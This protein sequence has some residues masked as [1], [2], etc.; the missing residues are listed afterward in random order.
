MTGRGEFHPLAGRVVG[1]LL[2]LLAPRVQREGASEEDSRLV[3]RADLTITDWRPRVGIACALRIENRG[4][5][6]VRLCWT[7]PQPPVASAHAVG[8]RVGA[9]TANGAVCRVNT[10]ERGVQ[11]AWR[12]G[13]PAVVLRQTGPVAA[14]IAAGWLPPSAAMAVTSDHVCAFEAGAGDWAGV[15]HVRLDAALPLRDRSTLPTVARARR[16]GARPASCVLPAAA[17]CLLTGVLDRLRRHAGGGVAFCDA[18]RDRAVF[19]G[20]LA[21]C[22]TRVL[23][24]QAAAPAVRREAPPAYQRVERLLRA[25]R[26]PFRDAAERARLARGLTALGLRHGLV[27]P[28]TALLA[29]D[30]AGPCG[31]LLPAHAAEG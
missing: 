5:A 12:A 11:R 18:A 26:E 8:V 22:P 31:E 30:A 10:A 23:L 7:V 13:R 14:S 28:W 20:Q 17:P 4:G 9:S 6:A 2:A 21:G 3:L 19:R 27:T 15:L 29:V 16:S 1:W 25:Y 24:V